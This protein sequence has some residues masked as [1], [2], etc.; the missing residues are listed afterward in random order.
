MLEFTFMSDGVH[1]I[2]PP[3]IILPLPRPSSAPNGRTASLPRT[4]V[5][6]FTLSKSGTVCRSSKAHLG[7]GIRW[8]APIVLSKQ[9][10]NTC[11]HIFNTC[12]HHVGRVKPRQSCRVPWTLQ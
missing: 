10:Y 7:T 8:M 9:L 12:R 5:L 1:L 2:T 6:M 11:L 3:R 4:V